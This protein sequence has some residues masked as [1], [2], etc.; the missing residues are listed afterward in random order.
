M[1]DMTL[2]IAKKVAVFFVLWSG[3]A[4]SDSTS[5]A[6]SSAH[7]ESAAVV[8]V[9]PRVA[10]TEQVALPLPSPDSACDPAWVRRGTLPTLNDPDFVHFD[11][12]GSELIIA[13]RGYVATSSPVGWQSADHE[14]MPA[15][16]HGNDRRTG[17]I[18]VHARA[19]D[20]VYVIGTRMTIVHWDGVRWEHQYSDGLD[21]D[22]YGMRVWVD[23]DDAE[24]L[25]KT[26]WVGG[27]RRTSPAMSYARLGPE[28]RWSA[29]DRGRW[30]ASV[31]LPEE[32]NPP[33]K[34][35][36]PCYAWDTM[37]FRWVF[38]CRGVAV[39]WAGNRREWIPLPPDRD[40]QDF[41][42]G[43]HGRDGERRRREIG[44]SLLL[45]LRG[46]LWR[47]DSEGWDLERT[48]DEPID[49]VTS[50]ESWIHLVTEHQWWA[51]RRC[52]PL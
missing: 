41:N 18:A 5:S 25:V 12:V 13:S 31:D 28:G 36:I 3:L 33:P 42:R 8:P 44:E 43:P 19:T 51:R 16:N 20:D 47:H 30:E 11:N 39:A 2:A 34:P 24:L 9:L 48:L 10:A 40:H 45:A 4:C 37:G 1:R 29:V 23:D 46:E 52:E 14:D 32:W 35:E 49:M 21:D 38:P 26:D 22:Y 15:W 17:F 27:S 7:E 50:D 6:T